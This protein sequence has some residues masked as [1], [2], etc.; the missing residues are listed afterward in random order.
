MIFSLY[1]FSDKVAFLDLFLRLISVNINKFYLFKI[2]KPL[3]YKGIRNQFQV[4]IIIKWI[5]N[6]CYRGSTSFFTCQ[7][8]MYNTIKSLKGN[9]AC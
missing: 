2:L 8:V 7:S 4:Y 9:G 3:N 1:V 6:M 5:Q